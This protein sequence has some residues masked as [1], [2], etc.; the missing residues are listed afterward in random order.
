VRFT[1]PEG[2]APALDGVELAV[3]PGRLLALV[4]PSGA[5]KTTLAMLLLRFFDPQSGRV[6]F[7]RDD[8]RAWRLDPLRAEL[9]MVA[10]DTHLFNATLRENLKLARPDADESALARAVRLGA[11]EDFVAG[12]PEGLD[13]RSASAACSSR[14]ASASAWRSPGL[15]QGRAGADPRRGDL[16]SRRAERGRDPRRARRADAR[17]H[18]RSVIAHR[19]SDGARRRRDRGAGGRASRSRSAPTPS[20]S[21]AAAPTPAS[22][23]ARRGRMAD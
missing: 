2:A 9:A 11:L 19:L 10:Q 7:R 18:R 5:G 16:A 8:L 1:Y 13:T 20:C 23:P 21:P 22:S 17:P 4:G 15:P 3:A 12:L 6:A 14:A